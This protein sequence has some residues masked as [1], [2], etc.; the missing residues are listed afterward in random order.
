MC[1]VLLGAVIGNAATAT[2]LQTARTINGTNFDGT[3]NIT[4]TKWGTSRNIALTGA[5]T[6]SANVDGSGNVT[7]TTT[8][9]N[10]ATLTGDMTLAAATQQEYQEGTEKQTQIN[11]N[12]PSGYN[13]D[14]CIVLAFATK[15]TGKNYSYGVGESPSYRAVTG[16]YK[17]N[18]VLGASSDNTKISLSVWQLS[19]STVTINYKIVLMKIA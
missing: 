5:I 4:T 1:L 15:I 7:I 13:K 19:T 17:R 2:K 9:G 16:S 11:I 18:I 14:N 6:G 10:I 3:G 8:Q 12:F